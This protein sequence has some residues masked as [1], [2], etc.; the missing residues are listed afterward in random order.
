MLY[1]F[2]VVVIVLFLFAY[3]NL[4]VYF[5]NAYVARHINSNIERNVERL[6]I[7]DWCN[8]D[9][10]IK[11][12]KS[13]IY[14]SPS[15]QSEQATSLFV[16]RLFSLLD[17]D[18]GVLVI[19][20]KCD[21]KKKKG[22]SVFDIPFMHENTLADMGKQWMKRF[23]KIPFIF[24]FCGSLKV[25]TRINR[26]NQFIKAECPISEIK[27]FCQKRNIRIDYYTIK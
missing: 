21:S 9:K 12:K 19:V 14:L 15:P 18:K 22:I 6:V 17:E 2:F 11:N 25:L 13:I 8:P 10:L 26:S 1:L 5:R 3:F 16:K 24:D 7:G 23:C 20:K 27:S 4:V